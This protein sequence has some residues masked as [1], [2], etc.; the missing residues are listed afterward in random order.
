MIYS[1][2]VLQVKVVKPIKRDENGNR[3]PDSD[4]SW[5]NVCKCRC[6]DNSTKEFMSDNGS[7]YRPNYHV[8]CD[9]IILV[10]T[11]DLVRCVDK[12]GNIRGQGTVYMIKKLNHLNYSELWM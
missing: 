10:S 6:D 12:D 5:Q 11:N 1:P 9:G 4:E 3:I 8:V 7:V 2:H